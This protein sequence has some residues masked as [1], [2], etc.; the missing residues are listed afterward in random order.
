MV[1]LVLLAM[2][3]SPWVHADE[4]ALTALP[5]ESAFATYQAYKDEAIGDWREANRVVD[6]VG[7]WRVYA[8]EARQADEADA[9]AG[10]GGR[11]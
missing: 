11:P 4:T 9:H 2:A 7:G 6:H 8:K 5:F 10:H 3:I 1:K